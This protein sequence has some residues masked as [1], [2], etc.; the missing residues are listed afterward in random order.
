M[1]ITNPCYCICCQILRKK[2]RVNESD[3]KPWM[4]VRTIFLLQAFLVQLS[5][6]YQWVCNAWNLT[7]H[8]RPGPP[9]LSP[10]FK[11]SF[12]IQIGGTEKGSFTVGSKLWELCL[13]RFSTL[14]W[15][16]P[17]LP[18]LDCPVLLSFLCPSVGLL[19][20]QIALILPCQRS[21]WPSP[22]FKSSL[23]LVAPQSLQCHD[24][25]PATTKTYM[26]PSLPCKSL[27]LL[28]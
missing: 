23:F 18:A 1:T 6:F 2:C 10:F 4:C 25:H 14:H 9:M 22:K 8:E 28:G 24:S 11:N 26:V 3:L 16:Y 13:R 15:N 7:Q 5:P 17:S 27:G 20:L 21:A 12:K 19:L